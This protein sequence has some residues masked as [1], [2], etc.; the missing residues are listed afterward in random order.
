[1][2]DEPLSLGT[3]EPAHA[4]EPYL[5]TPRSLEACKRHGVNPVEL[6]EIP[7][8]EFRKAFPT[9]PD[10]AQRRYERIDGARRRIL[11]NVIHEWDQI[12][13]SGWKPDEAASKEVVNEAIIKVPAHAHSSML[14]RQAQQF[15]EI[16][17]QQWEQMNRMVGIEL[18]KAKRKIAMDEII[19]K[20]NAIG[21]ANDN[22][23][24][25]MQQK[26]AELFEANVQRQKQLEKERAL[27]VKKIQE[28]EMA[29]AR[30]MKVQKEQKELAEKRNR[31][32]REAERRS[33]EEYTRELKEGIIEK[34]NQSLDAKVADN[35][36]KDRERKQRI[37]EQK[38]VAAYE[39]AK[40]RKLTE[41][42][43]AEAKKHLEYVNTTKGDERR[44][45]LEQAEAENKKKREKELADA[46]ARGHENNM[47]VQ[48]KLA[49]IRKSKEDAAAEKVERT[50]AQIALKEALFKKEQDKLKAEQERRKNIKM[51][52]QE[53][54]ELAAQRRKKADEYK[55]QQL[56]ETIR[57]KQEKMQAQD[58]GNATLKHMRHIMAEIMEKTK[59][60]LKDGI[61]D[62]DHKGTLSPDKV[63]DKVFEV[64]SGVM[65]P[66]LAQKFVMQQVE[67]AGD[68]ALEAELAMDGSEERASTAP[69]QKKSSSLGLGND[70][71]AATKKKPGTASTARRRERST[72]LPLKTLIPKAVAKNVIETKT[73]VVDGIRTSDP[74]ASLKETRPV[75]NAAQS[76]IMKQ[77]MDKSISETTQR[78][79]RIKE[80]SQVT[81]GDY[82]DFSRSSAS[83][84]G[85]AM[86]HSSA[87]EPGEIRLTR[88]IAGGLGKFDAATGDVAAL[89]DDAS[90]G[91]SSRG[92]GVATF[93]RSPTNTQQM[94]MPQLGPSLEAVYDEVRAGG[95]I[96]GPD[97]RDLRTK[98]N[99]FRREYSKDHPLAGGSGKYKKERS[100]GKRPVGAGAALDAVRAHK[101]NPVERLAMSVNVSDMRSP[102]QATDVRTR[103][104]Q[105]R[106][107]QN[108]VL[109]RVLDEERKF[110]E[111][112]ARA[113]KLAKD[114]SERGRLE[115]VFAEERRRA[116][117]RIVNLTKE[118]E[119]RLRQAVVSLK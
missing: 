34:F 29:E 65:F 105:L 37:Q 116:S 28:M 92:R 24:K 85:G 44:E 36:R 43:M 9:D 15:R 113:G 63:V 72:H 117:E 76:S 100:T 82:D 106:K 99:E 62:L 55:Q 60:E 21:E 73:L 26:R 20:Q 61:H 108:Q 66:H 107:E 95:V 90:A 98:P 57:I 118:H 33:R 48:Q 25:L 46:K 47:A 50:Q 96:K 51:I 53:A 104:E 71:I 23:K 97:G 70:D 30:A 31:E 115:L 14:E 13:E 83:R 110:E 93:E 35:A 5:N 16:E 39:K 78:I 102:N 11:K 4:L 74:S 56:L 75:R 112:R 94:S 77:Q 59:L 79:D 1:M 45:Q 2:Q 119:E 68:A 32:R 49:N 101:A 41:D 103:V 114:P 38:E 10:A 18:S 88:P 19:A 3:F 91:G 109:L 58:E 87:L 84:G 6:V 86:S 42:R 7:F 67:D 12:C 17:K 27:E 8:D 22:A 64:S 54:F 89:F 40:K 81:D 69:S 80:M 111:D 52:R